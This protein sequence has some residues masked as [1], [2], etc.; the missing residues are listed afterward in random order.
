MVDAPVVILINIYLN[1]LQ[2]VLCLNMLTSFLFVY[3]E[4]NIKSLGSPVTQKKRD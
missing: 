2:R 4:G 1:R 3:R